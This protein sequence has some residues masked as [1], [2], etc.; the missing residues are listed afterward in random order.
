M[1]R[2]SFENIEQWF[3]EYTEG[4]LS[5]S[6]EAQFMDFLEENPSLIEELKV[7]K[8][9][10]VVE[11]AD[12]VFPST[13]QL[14]KTTPFLLRPLS[15]A[16][17]A[18]LFLL[19]A[20]VGFLFYPSAPAYSLTQIDTK[21]IPVGR[22]QLFTQQMN[23]SPPPPSVN[24]RIPA[25][26]NPKGTTIQS[27]TTLLQASLLPVT[28]RENGGETIVNNG[29]SDTQLMAHNQATNDGVPSLENSSSFVEPLQPLADVDF[30]KQKISLKMKPVN[31][32]QLKG[33]LIAMKLTKASKTAA[34]K[35]IS[36]NKLKASV[37][38]L[39][40]VLSQ[41][42]ALRRTHRPNYQ[43]PMTTVLSAIPAM[44]GDGNQNKVNITSRL[45]W[46]NQ[47]TAQLMNS[48]SWDG[49]MKGLL[50]GLGVDVNYNAY[51]YNKINNY[52]VGI[53]YSPK[54]KLS[55]NFRIEPGVHFKM[56]V[57][58]LK[59]AHPLVGGNIE[60]KR[61]NIIPLFVGSKQQSGKQLWYKDIGASLVLNTKWFYLGV[62]ADNLGRHYNNYY[63][64]VLDKSY[65]SHLHYTAVIGSEYRPI[66]Y[67]F[68]VDGYLFYQNF[69]NLNELWAG[70]NFQYKWMQIG[71]GVSTNKDFGGSVGLIFNRVDIHYNIDYT[72][73]RL[74]GHKFLSHQLSL[75]I[76]LGSSH[77]RTNRSN[78][79]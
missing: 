24:K 35:P 16:S 38:K 39:K 51:N 29:N 45:Q 7:W 79:K 27:A 73:S 69:G 66:N 68:K 41:P 53:T 61:E 34:I 2:P 42:L 23:V 32:A 3:F 17:I 58:D 47:S 28:N 31:I 59:N 49:Y 20:W 11:A 64:S 5:S 67:N 4:N 55:N 10:R 6:H 76:L 50:G 30:S 63:S 40:R 14:L 21:I 77:R 44:A 37:R 9:A 12:I 25:H 60:M 36:T 54:I 46:A 52:S 18:V 75:R 48:I 22:A 70:G 19:V 78:F 74:L 71:A 65:R 15:M 33:D 62:N 8:S 1:S 13:A 57:M 43:V 56:G 72:N 26:S